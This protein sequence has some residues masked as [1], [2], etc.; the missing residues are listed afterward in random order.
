MRKTILACLLR[1]DNFLRRWITYFS[2]ESG[3]HPKHRLTNYHQFF[4]DRVSPNETVLDIGCGFGLLAYDVARKARQV[5]GLDINKQYLAT[6]RSK[7]RL[8]NLTYIHGDATACSLPSK[9]NVIILSNTLEHIQDRVAFLKKLS[10]IADKF[11][12][13]V[14]MINRDW[15]VILK[16]ELGV[17]YRL[18][19]THYVEYTEKTFR[20]ELD[21]AGLAITELTVRFGEIYS[22]ARPFPERPQGIFTTR[23]SQPAH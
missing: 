11:L 12:I 4:L 3:V 14:P 10:P 7:H 19:L 6:A 22:V 18:D 15:L 2:L 16:K 5:T 20:Q 1:L 9:F 23:L 17:E 21:N 13:R 8:P